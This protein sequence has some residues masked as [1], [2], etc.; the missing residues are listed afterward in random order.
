M[1]DTGSGD[2]IKRI[3]IAEF[4]KFG[5]LQEVNRLFFHP[6]GLAL[7][8]VI[9]RDTGEEWL[10]GIWDYREDPFGMAYDSIDTE[11]INRVAAE[12]EKRAVARE[13][14]FPGGIQG[15][16]LELEDQV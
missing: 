15:V 14:L 9:D 16:P 8:V 3:D 5:Y 10:G 6:L 7:E 2:S 4:R 1:S 11:K 13:S 12:R